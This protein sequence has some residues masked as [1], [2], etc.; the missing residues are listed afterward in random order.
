MD[1]FE[2]QDQARRRTRWLVVYFIVAVVL[3]IVAL[4]AVVFFAA[5]YTPLSKHL[6]EG[7]GFWSPVLFL[8]TAALVLVTIVGAMLLKLVELRSGGGAVA[9]SLGG[10]KVDPDTRNRQERQLLNVVEEMAI[11]SGTPVPEVY[12]LY[13][14]PGLN[15]FAA[16]YS[17]NDAAVA[18]TKGLLDNSTRDELQ[19]VIA[20]EFSH[21]LNGDMRLNI[22]LI[23]ILFGILAIAVIGK[24]LLRV[25]VYSGFRS[26][27]RSGKEGGGAAALLLIFLVGVAVMAIGY[28]GVFFGRLI[29]SAVSRQREFLADSAAVQFTRNPDGIA[30]AL[31]RIGRTS[32]GS[33]MGSAHAEETAHLFFA[34]GL[35]GLNNLGA[36]F[37]THPPL[38]VRIRALQP[39]WEGSFLDGP[40]RRQIHERRKASAERRAR[41]E[42]PPPVPHFALSAANVM[43]A[44]GSLNPQ[45]VERAYDLRES[46]PAKLSEAIHETVNARAVVFC[47]LLDPDGGV[48]QRQLAWLQEGAGPGLAQA[49]HRLWPLVQSVGPGA[50]LPLLTL[51]IPALAQMSP[52]QYAAFRD[53][54]ETLVRADQRV[55]VFEFALLRI[56]KDALEPRIVGEPRRTR[57]R[58]RSPVGPAQVAKE[59]SQVLSWVAQTG[60]STPKAAADAF[61][62]RLE[63]TIPYLKDHLRFVPEDL[64][65][66]DQLNLAF[67]RLATAAFPVR[68]NAIQFA[69]HLVTADG[70]VTIEESELLRA[71]AISLDCPIPPLH[72]NATKPPV[73]QP[74]AS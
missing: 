54:A 29:Q 3:I 34:S 71:F 45:I 56:L 31:K 9:H 6:P 63:T 2:R 39:S 37:A 1:F 64:L 52:E 26:N 8:Q 53:R 44:V 5:P 61:N 58:S 19:G 46:I 51:C 40:S 10:S 36:L 23:G 17:P 38:E 57:R 67:D 25:M 27:R 72:L 20:H 59:L 12:I 28:I 62:Q 14:E 11:A 68:R 60:V 55:T 35:R 33:R 32:G 21:I 13:G 42:T 18:V 24:G 16:G 70:E 4:Y 74:T 22:R 66:P 69:A 50:R 73:S 15:A 47:L 65:D 49:V 43:N 41:R 48:Q 30:N 7:G